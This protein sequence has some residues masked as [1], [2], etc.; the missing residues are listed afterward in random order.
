[1]QSRK[2]VRNQ[3]ASL[4]VGA[5]DAMT[6]S[7]IFFMFLSEVM[8]R[9]LEE[10]ARF[11]LFPVAAA[12][13]LIRAGLAWRQAKLDEGR[14]GTLAA[15]GVETVT[16]LAVSTAVIGGL[17]LGAVFA[18]VSP[19][20]FVVT[21]AA[22]TLFHLGSAAYY[23]AKSFMPSISN[24]ERDAFRSAARS[25]AV[26]ALAVGLAT[27]AIGFVMIAAKPIVAIVGVIAGLIGTAYSLYKFFSTPTSSVVTRAATPANTQVVEINRG[28]TNSAELH[29]RVGMQVTQTARQSTQA[30]VIPQR[31]PSPSFLGRPA[32]AQ[33]VPN[34]STLVEPRRVSYSL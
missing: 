8:H 34:S 4:I 11:A 19:I 30:V 26:G 15:A 5:A 12:L 17:A 14:N 27:I 10:T 21:M 13:S 29:R 22:K 20:I 9:M 7:T 2:S 6:L 23:L 33:S 31:T 18:A 32:A 3:Q 25:H 1:M 24:D 28:T 16:A